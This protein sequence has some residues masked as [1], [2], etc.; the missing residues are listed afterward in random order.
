[1]LPVVMSM[2]AARNPEPP[3]RLDC[4]AHRWRGRPVRADIHRVV[5]QA[6]SPTRA[7]TRGRVRTHDITA[8]PLDASLFILVAGGDARL[9]ELAAS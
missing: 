4:P 8:Q 6:H 1:V 3:A 9:T 2:P 5:D 7:G